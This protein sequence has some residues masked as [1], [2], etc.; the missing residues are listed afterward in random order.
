M[1]NEINADDFMDTKELTV[2]EV[3]NL[4]KE[5]T[6]IRAEKKAQKEVMDEI[7]TRLDVAETTLIKMLEGA[8]K[9]S[10]IAEGYG[11]VKLSY[12]MAVQTPKT[13]EDKLAF[14]KWLAENKG[15]EVADAYL[16]VNSQ[17]L[18]SLY[19]ELQE[20]YAEKGE[21][22]QVDGIGEPLTRVKLSLTKA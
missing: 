14:F 18:N 22:L 3:D 7:N 6:E 10:Y 1:S 8:G 13:T 4:I 2:A 5:I 20:E 17:A 21:V 19:N 9:T 12:I 15:R 16:T 11:K